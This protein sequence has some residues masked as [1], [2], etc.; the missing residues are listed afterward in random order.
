MSVKKDKFYLDCTD[1]E[2]WVIKYTS[3]KSFKKIIGK[4]EKNKKKG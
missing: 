3:R 1:D 4:G 2:R